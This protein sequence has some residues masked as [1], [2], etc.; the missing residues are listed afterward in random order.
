MGSENDLPYVAKVTVTPSFIV[1]VTI[2]CS[3]LIGA[4]YGGTTS[5]IFEENFFLLLEVDPHSFS[6][7]LR[8]SSVLD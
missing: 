7:R 5:K 1:G 8:R 2:T 4:L 3:F 6:C